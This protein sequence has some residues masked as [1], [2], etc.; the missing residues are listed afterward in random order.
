MVSED[1]VLCEIVTEIRFLPRHAIIMSG[2]PPTPHV[3]TE[4]IL[5]E[6]D[7]RDLSRETTRTSGTPDVVRGH[8]F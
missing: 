2:T 1:L 7:T 5:I 3:T 4:E 6:T 8:Y